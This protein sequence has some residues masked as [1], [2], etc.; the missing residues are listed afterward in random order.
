MFPEADVFTLIATPS[1]LPQGLSGRR[2]TSSFLE[3]IPGGKRMHRHLLPLYPYAV[4]QLDLTPYDLVLTSDSGP[5]KGV[6]TN[7]NAIHICYC[8][9]PMRYLWDSYHAYASKMSAPSRFIFSLSAHYVRNWDYQAA[10]RVTHFL[11]NSQYVAGRIRHFYGRISTVLHPP[12][13]TEKGFIAREHDDYYLAVGRLVQYKRTDILI[14]ACNRL[15][16]RLRIIGEGPDMKRLRSIAGP[17]I[18]FL[19]KANDSDLW[20][21]YAHCQALLFAADEDFGMV[22]LEAQACGRPVVAYGKGGALETVRG[23]SRQTVRDRLREPEATGIFF[24]EQ[25][26][27]A[28]TDAILRLEAIEEDFFPEA[29]REHALQFDTSIFIDRMRRFLSET[30]S[31]SYEGSWS[32]LGTEEESLATV[33]R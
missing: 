19:G 24:Y 31:T 32:S 7:Q 21:S 15:G 26:A 23:Y 20:N 2:L 10:Q 11:A 27:E 17:T 4:E 3:S 16:R 29:I 18:E 9:S 33:P 8:H 5:M 12:I 1:Y 13:D 28:V 22:P 14:E 6:I 25:T 30:L